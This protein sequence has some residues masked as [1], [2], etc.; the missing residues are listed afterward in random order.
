MQRKSLSDILRADQ[1]RLQD[2]WNNTQAAED[3]GAP[4][5]AGE[6]LARIVSGEL[7]NA[8]TKGTGGYKLAFRV[9]EG[10]HRGRQFWHDI[11]LTE[12]ALPMAKRDLAKLGVTRLEQLETPL[13]S[14]IR[15][16]VKLALRKDDNGEEYNRVR[17]F[18][19]IGIDPPEVDPFAP[20]DGPQP[21]P[22]PLAAATVAGGKHDGF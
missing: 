4:L 12:A 17:T 22:Q 1:R 19:V 14:G 6:Y 11:Y 13:P 18:E 5:P 10:D 21:S 9:L 2:A 16:K 3:F 20:A 7:F 15:C 8:R